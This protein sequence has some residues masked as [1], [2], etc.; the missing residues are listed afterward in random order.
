MEVNKEKHRSQANT[1][2]M[3]ETGAEKPINPE[4]ED[5]SAKNN[6][7]PISVPPHD[8]APHK[9]PC[10]QTTRKN[11]TPVG[12]AAQLS[13]LG[14]FPPDQPGPRD[15]EVRLN[16]E[17]EARSSTTHEEGANFGGVQEGAGPGHPGVRPLAV[18]LLDLLDM[19]QDIPLTGKARL[20]GA[21]EAMLGMRPTERPNGRLGPLNEQIDEPMDEPE[22]AGAEARSPT[23]LPSYK[24][25]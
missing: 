6:P 24:V 18:H 15:R 19:V 9:E 23:N 21:G 17:Q 10:D 7:N 20:G 1:N 12:S 5:G 4:T 22:E 2:P 11:D 3:M 13:N 14:R 25:T 16:K 8:P